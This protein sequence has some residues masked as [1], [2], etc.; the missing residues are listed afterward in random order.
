M[1]SAPPPAPPQG[2]PAGYGPPPGYGQ[3]PQW[4]PPPEQKKKRGFFKKLML[5]FLALIALIILIQA[6][7]GGSDSADT[8]NASSDTTADAPAADAPADPPPA[9]EPAITVSAQELIDL[10][11]SN[12]ANAKNTYEDKQVTVTG[13]VGNIDAS[14]DYFSLDPAPD[15]FIITGVQVQTDDQFADQVASFSKG[16]PVTV[17]GKITGV[18]ELMG[19]TL[20]AETIQ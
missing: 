19:Y 3:Q 14:G 1:S 12:A 4:G 6:V 17:T 2:P 7:S 18:G 5:G 16:Q 20:E 11:E 8:D 10:L 13:V 15:S 9:A